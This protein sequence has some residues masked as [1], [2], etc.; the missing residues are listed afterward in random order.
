MRGISRE[1]KSL[2]DLTIISL[3]RDKP[4]SMAHSFLSKIPSISC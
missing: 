2:V 3:T 4:N 1:Q